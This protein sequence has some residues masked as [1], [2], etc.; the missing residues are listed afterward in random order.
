[1]L[2]KAGNAIATSQRMVFHFSKFFFSTFFIQL[3]FFPFWLVRLTGE[4]RE[5]RI[6]IRPPKC[7]K[8]SSYFQGQ[9]GGVNLDAT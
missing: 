6:T 1:M 8:T 7:G 3:R 4:M 5:H 2:K 9:N